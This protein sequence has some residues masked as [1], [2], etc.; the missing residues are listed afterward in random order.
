MLPRRARNGREDSTASLTPSSENLAE[1]LI[2]LSKLERAKPALTAIASESVLTASIAIAVRAAAS[3]PQRVNPTTSSLSA[4]SPRANAARDS[5]SAARAWLAIWLRSPG[6]ALSAESRRLGARCLRRSQLRHLGDKNFVRRLGG[7]NCRA[8]DS[9]RRRCSSGA[10]TLGFHRD[11]P[12]AA[13]CAAPNHSSPDSIGSA[14]KLCN[15]QSASA[16]P[17]PR[18]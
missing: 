13:D 2:Q 12:V 5:A 18:S 6:S 1:P 11:I 8:Q 7:Y 15:A 14:T 16:A 17:W 9:N 3:M 4:S 10:L